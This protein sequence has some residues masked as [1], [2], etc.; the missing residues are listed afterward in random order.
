LIEDFSRDLYS[1]VIIN[2]SSPIS[3]QELEY[4]AKELSKISGAV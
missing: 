1:K 3:N 4:M 2:F